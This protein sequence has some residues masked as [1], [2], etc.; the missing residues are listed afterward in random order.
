LLSPDRGWIRTAAAYALSIGL[1]ALSKYLVEDPIRFRAT[2][3]RGRSGSLAF[4]ALMVG[5]AMLWSA[6]PAPAPT[7]IDITKLG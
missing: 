2:W 5:L 4:V 1:A 7:T 6:L 3:A